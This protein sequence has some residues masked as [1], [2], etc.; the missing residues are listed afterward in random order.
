LFLPLQGG[1]TL[2]GAFALMQAL[3]ARQAAA[4]RR[5]K[6]HDLP[7]LIDGIGVAVGSTQCAQVG[8]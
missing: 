4:S 8:H 6:T 7:A 3:M 5:A 1:P 2:N